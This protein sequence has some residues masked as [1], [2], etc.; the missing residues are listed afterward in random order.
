MCVHGS[1]RGGTTPGQPFADFL[2]R[3]QGGWARP[4]HASFEHDNIAASFFCDGAITMFIRKSLRGAVNIAN[5]NLNEMG[6]VEKTFVE[7]AKL[8]QLRL[9]ELKSNLTRLSEVS[10]SKPD[11]PPT[12]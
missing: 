10:N 6:R 3:T 5:D 1:V 9:E 12:R 2:M 4:P 11:K 7:E 8:L